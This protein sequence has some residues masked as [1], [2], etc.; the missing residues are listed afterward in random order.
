MRERLGA[1]QSVRLNISHARSVTA[2]ASESVDSHEALIVA[3]L[4]GGSREDG[5]RLRRR[6]PAMRPPPP[7]LGQDHRPTR[8][9]HRTVRTRTFLDTT[10]IL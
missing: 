1:V 3:D 9:L 10:G 2:R 6:R 4:D 5:D 7:P 8:Q